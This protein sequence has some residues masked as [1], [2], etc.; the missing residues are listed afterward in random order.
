MA[1]DFCNHP[2]RTRHD[3]V[4]EEGS[5]TSSDDHPRSICQAFGSHAII[6]S[7]L[8]IVIT[9]ATLAYD[10][11]DNL[12]PLGTHVIKACVAVAADLLALSHR[13]LAIEYVGIEYVA[14]YRT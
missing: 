1:H 13:A 12:V 6:A 2:N 7:A 10:N 14:N 4:L 8:G 9:V 5:C 11:T 3:I